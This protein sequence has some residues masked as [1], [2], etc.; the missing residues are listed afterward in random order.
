MKRPGNHWPYLILL[1]LG[2][3]LSAGYLTRAQEEKKQGQES[4]TQG[5]GSDVQS[6]VETQGQTRG[7]RR[8]S[9]VSTVVNLAELARRE[10]LGGVPMREPIVI[11]KPGPGPLPRHLSDSA[12]HPTVKE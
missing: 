6:G 1:I 5:L 3:I 10:S 2:V 7:L 8:G 9:I 4:Q 11:R 12:S